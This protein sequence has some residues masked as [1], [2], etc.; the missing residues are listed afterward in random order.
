MLDLVFF[1]C[2]MF[3]SWFDDSGA[4]GPPVNDSWAKFFLLDRFR[5]A[6]V[7]D[8]FASMK[9]LR[10]RVPCYPAYRGFSTL[11]AFEQ[12]ARLGCH[13]IAVLDADSKVH[14]IVT[15]SMLMSLLAQS[16]DKLGTLRHM[17]VSEMMPG[18]AKDLKTCTEETLAIRAFKTMA[19]NNF[20]GL[21]VVDA[22]GALV[23]NLSVRDLR[24]IGTKAGYFERLWM[25][26]KD[27]KQEVRKSFPSQTPPLPIT[28]TVHDTLET[29]LKRMDDGNIGRIVVVERRSENLTVPIRVITHRDV[30]MLLCFRMGLEP[31]FEVKPVAF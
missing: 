25:T 30:L 3:R 5:E 18:L 20:S 11:W 17:K 9:M 1:V 16:L 4:A 24:G 28:V 21:P 10:S 22:N 31:V 23:D 26:V 19:T 7:S 14:N 27:F 6:T 13:R 12:M 15:Q 8:M 2:E 29:V